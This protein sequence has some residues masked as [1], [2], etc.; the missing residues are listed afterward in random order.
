MIHMK[1]LVQFLAFAGSTVL[2]LA[3]NAP[4]TGINAAMVKMFGETKAFTA[5]ANVRLLDSQQRETSSM[6]M[7]MALREGKLRTEVDMAEM[8][9]PGV[10]PEAAG[11]MKQAGMD[12]MVTLIDPQKKLHLMIYPNAKSY[13]ELPAG[14]DDGSGSVQSKDLGEETIDGRV[15]KK[16]MLTSTDAKGRTHEATVWQARDLKN[17]PVQMEM[18]QKSNIVLV[19]FQ[20]PKLEAPAASEFEVPAGFSK[21]ANFQAMLQAA[22]LKMF[23]NSAQ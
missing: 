7:T 10:P 23:S 18:K 9:M 6:P 12:K 22:M 17:F 3:Q 8:K 14:E 13:A 5:K 11:M 4:D 20:N 1:R 15:C 19:K 21:Y 16:V 2:A